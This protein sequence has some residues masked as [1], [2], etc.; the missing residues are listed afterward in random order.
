MDE[1]T[2]K[3]NGLVYA[4]EGNCVVGIDT[5]SFDFMGTVPYGPNRIEEEAFSCCSIKNII[6]PESV[7]Y[8]G[9]NLFCNSTELQTVH[10]PAN[11]RNLSPFMFCGCKS[12]TKVEMPMEVEDFTEG[13]FAE[14]SSLKE[15]PFCNGVK[16]LPEGVFDGCSSIETLVIPDSVTKICTGAISGCTSLKTIVLPKNLKELEENWFSDC[17]ALCHIRI[18]DENP[19]FK[20]DDECQV[21]YRKNAGGN[22]TVL[23]RIENKDEGSIPSLK[24]ETYEN[25]SI[26]TYDE[27]DDESNEDV[28]IILNE[29]EKVGVLEENMENVVSSAEKKEEKA[30]DQGGM[31]ARLAEILGQNKMYD[32]GDFSIMDI[33]EASE[34]E[35]ENAKLESKGGEEDYSHAPVVQISVPSEPTGSMEDRLK[36]IMGQEENAGGFSIFDIP[37]ASDAELEANKLLEGEGG[38]KVEADPETLEDDSADVPLPEA[39]E[40]SADKNFMQNLMF[41]TGKVEQQNTGIKRDTPNMLFVFAE[42]VVETDLGKKFSNHLI[43]CCQRLAQIHEYTSIYFLNQVRL[44][45][46]KFVAQLADFM[47]DKNVVIACEGG[48]LLDISEKTKIMADT[49]GVSLKK[50]DIE[51]ETELAADSSVP[52]LKLIIQDNLTD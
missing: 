6:L 42:N 47:K 12:L 32:E 13:L 33:P 15:I 40:V 29:N 11:L 16:T 31:D 36:E 52:V 19:D 14:C 25:P 44:D 46:D 41:E 37:V 9:A 27:S 49:I 24:E 38:E 5:S 21:L 3:K 43:K 34:E 50:E 35:I 17:P 39:A 2:S 45:N 23:L 18:S 4:D 8:V 1:S 30:S 48:N 22:E 28:E 51:R 7:D 20:T 10:L 26:I